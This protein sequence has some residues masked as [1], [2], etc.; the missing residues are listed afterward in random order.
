MC[1]SDLG[2]Q[3]VLYEQYL[4]RNKTGT[5]VA[6]PGKS[7]HNC[8]LAVDISMVENRTSYSDLYTTFSKTN[9]VVK[10]DV[11]SRVSRG[12]FGP[13]AQWM[14]QNCGRFGFYW[15]GWSY[16]ELWHYQLNVDLARQ[17]G[18]IDD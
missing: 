6:E 14:V 13:V 12:E 5:Q 2:Q 18:L 10:E 1:S 17:A 11:F 3:R 8:G 9:S 16:K 7:L 4:A 15:D